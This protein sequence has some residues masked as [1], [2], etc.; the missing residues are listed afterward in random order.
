MKIIAKIKTD[1]PTKFGIPRQ[2]GLIDN[3]ATIVFEKEYRFDEAL[4]GIEEYS[5]LWLLW[6]FS[7]VKDKEWSPTVRPPRLGGNKR[8]GVFATRSPFRPNPVGLSCV[9]LL[10]CE[11]TNEGTVLIVKGADLMNNTPIYDIK[12]YIPY[13]DCK[14]E[15]KG[16]F[17]EEK[18]NYALFVECA[19]DSLSL[20]PT[21]KQSPLLQLLSQDPRPAYIDDPARIY[22][23]EYAGFEV[24]F[25]VEN[26]TLFVIDVKLLNNSC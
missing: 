9:E 14:P 4:R 1:F 19:E 17:S 18:K 22:G 8:V 12:P 25:K 2:S 20:I 13:V 21:E 10:G 15:A 5:H 3:V 26:D 16:S 23:F 7:E 11:K 6:E 24:K